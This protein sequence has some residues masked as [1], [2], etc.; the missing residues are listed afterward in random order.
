MYWPFD[1]TEHKRTKKPQYEYEEKKGVK[2]TQRP[3]Y[4][5]AQ[6]LAKIKVAAD[7]RLDDGVPN[8]QVVVTV[9][10]YFNDSQKRS[11]VDSIRLANLDLLALLPEPVAAALAQGLGKF[12]G[13]EEN[14]M[15]VYD[16]GG[17]TLDVTILKFSN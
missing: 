8:R 1:I 14:Y 13:A 10:A 16:F 12:D 3:E 11:T 17:G 7:E 2:T 6:V 4:V 9:P 15:L 5:S